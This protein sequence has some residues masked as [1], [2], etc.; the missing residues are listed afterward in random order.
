MPAPNRDEF[1]ILS[2]RRSGESTDFLRLWHRRIRH[3]LGPDRLSAAYQ[4]D[5]VTR[6]LGMDAVAMV[7]H[8]RDG[9][10]VR[11]GLRGSLRPALALDGRAIDGLAPAARLWEIP[12]GIVEA[13]DV[14]EEGLR[15]RCRIEA[16][17]E[18]GADLPAE[19]FQPLGNPVW[20]SPGVFAERVHLFQAELTNTEFTVPQG[21]GSPMEAESPIQWPT[22]D[23]AL[24]LSR[25]GL[26]DAKTELALVRFSALV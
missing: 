18:M 23:E 12:A 24:V 5:S 14:G 13:G 3:R 15:N 6:E 19:A 20:L 9:A 8:Y 22:L 2:E 11:V 21:D 7:L 26:S 25:S 1:E 17:E 4:C 10:A 16:Q